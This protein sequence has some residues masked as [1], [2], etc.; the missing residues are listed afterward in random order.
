MNK[1]EHFIQFKLEPILYTKFGLNLLA[2]FTK[3]GHFEAINIIFPSY[4]NGIA[5]K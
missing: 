5:S 2:H 1:L 4:T 3:L